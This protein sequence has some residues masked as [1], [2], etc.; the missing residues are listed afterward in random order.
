[1]LHLTAR[2]GGN[3]A[4]YLGKFEVGILLPFPSDIVCFPIGYGDSQASFMSISTEPGSVIREWVCFAL[5]S[6]A[7]LL[8]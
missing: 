7:K 8:S 1:M 3:H 5:Y 4:N 2:C 6:G